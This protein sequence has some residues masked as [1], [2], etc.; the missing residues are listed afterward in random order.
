MSENPRKGVPIVAPVGATVSNME[1]GPRKDTRIRERDLLFEA[2]LKVAGWEYDT[3]TPSA[4]GWLNAAVKELRSVGATPD[5][6]LIRGRRYWDRN[7]NRTPRRPSP[8][9]LAKNWPALVETGALAAEIL[10]RNCSHLYQEGD[11]EDERGRYCVRGRTW[12][13]VVQLRLIEG[14]A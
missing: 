12:S 4:R 11:D 13:G 8:S 6:V 9:T 2:V 10:P 3:L 1:V 7:P 5:E 14:S